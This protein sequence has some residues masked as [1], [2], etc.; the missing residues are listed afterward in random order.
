MEEEDQGERVGSRTER[1]EECGLQLGCIV[2]EKNKYK[3]KIHLMVAMSE[4]QQVAIKFQD[5]AHHKARPWWVNFRGKKR[6]GGLQFQNV[7]CCSCAFTCCLL[8]FSTGIW[9]GVNGCGEIPTA[10]NVVW[11][12]HGRIPFYWSFLPVDYYE[13]VNCLIEVM[14]LYKKSVSLN[15]VFMIKGF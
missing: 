7:S 3:E 2:W 12:F 10:F 1:M 11:L 13:N 4:E 14:I 8:P 5:S 15:R 9:Y 6:P